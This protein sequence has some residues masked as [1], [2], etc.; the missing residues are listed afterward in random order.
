M[1]DNAA[2]L[3]SAAAGNG[4][5]Q[6]NHQVSRNGFTR[7]TAKYVVEKTSGSRYTPHF[8]FL[9]GTGSAGISCASRGMELPA[10]RH[11]K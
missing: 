1:A 6:S 3:N 8:N 10:T 4:R 9:T 11:H 7:K 2:D 5:S